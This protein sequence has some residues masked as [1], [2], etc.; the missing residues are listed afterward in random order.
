MRLY[1]ICR[2]AESALDGEDARLHGGRWNAPGR[3]VIYTSTS[4]SLAAL[5]YLVHISPED[6]PDDLV[7]S[8]IEVPDEAPIEMVSVADLPDGWDQDPE[9]PACKEIGTAWLHAGSA[10]AL[11]VPSAPIPE[12]LNV[13]LN[14]EHP[15]AHRV[16]VVE[17]HPFSFDPRLLV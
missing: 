9:P 17:E 13:L 11:R 4:L 14:P 3:P 10:L 7:A 15:A 12:E 16:R 5:E 1:R 2:A 6:V 8:L